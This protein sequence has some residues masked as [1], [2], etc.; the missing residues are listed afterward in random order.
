[1]LWFCILRSEFPWWPSH[2]SGSMGPSE[3]KESQLELQVICNQ[4]VDE[5]QP[6][7][8]LG[9]CYY[10]FSVG[11]VSFS[12]LRPFPLSV[13]VVL[14]VTLYCIFNKMFLSLTHPF[15]KRKTFSVSLVPSTVQLTS[16]AYTLPQF[17]ILCVMNFLYPPNLSSTVPYFVYSLVWFFSE[18][19]R[20]SWLLTSLLC[21]IT[22]PI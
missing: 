10:S 18:R 4:L 5:I 16:P 3:L 11:V 12:K 1:M 17:Y 8:Q 7:I 6:M 2:V 13:N 22:K 20:V 19:Y 15:R 9:L 14:S 21:I